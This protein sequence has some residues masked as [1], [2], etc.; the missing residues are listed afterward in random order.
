MSSKWSILTSLP[1][2]SIVDI[3]IG[4]LG[5]LGDGIADING[6]PLFVSKSCAG[7]RLQVR[8]TQETSQYLRGAI[9]SIISP[10]PDRITPDCP[11]YTEC[12]GC[13]LQHLRPEAYQTHK[14]RVVQQAIRQ[15]GYETL[16]DAMIFIPAGR[17][18]RA[19]FRLHQ[20]EGT[21]KAAYFLPGTNQLMPID[22]CLLLETALQEFLLRLT[23]YLSP[24]KYV[25]HIASVKLTAL[26]DGIDMVLQLSKPIPHEALLEL[27][28][29]VQLL[30]LSISLDDKSPEIITEANPVT[31]TL[32]GY[33]VPFPPDSFLQATEEAQDRLIAIVTQHTKN[34]NRIADLFCGIGTYGFALA[35]DK[36]IHGVD[37]HGSMIK[38]L[39]KSITALGLQ[40]NFTAK[41][42]DLLKWPLGKEELSRYEAVV[43]NPPRPGAKGQT[44]AIAQS[45]VPLVV[46]ISCNPASW[47]RDAKALKDSGFRLSYVQGIDQF[48]YS[49][50]LEIASVFTR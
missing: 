30:R 4:S 41:S 15:A 36:K 39:H 11:H 32:G 38:N 33:Q 31:I 17:R 14:E 26:S 9:E 49:P 28:E 43:I 37:L 19:E 35:K 3:T 44:L 21:V 24:Q 13:Q 10:S 50:H 48:V 6:K 42:Q 47:A 27:A 34:A 18:R 7:D 23:E 46:M 16:P 5:G 1:N 29:S 8:I 25:H 45:S 12:G 2:S 22:Q 40:K 20:Q